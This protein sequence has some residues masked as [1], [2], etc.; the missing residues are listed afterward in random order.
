LSARKAVTMMAKKKKKVMM[1]SQG[2][3]MPEK[4]FDV[5]IQFKGRQN[6]DKMLSKGRQKVNKMLSKGQQNVAKR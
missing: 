4:K 2:S 1:P 3:T 6:V 5:D